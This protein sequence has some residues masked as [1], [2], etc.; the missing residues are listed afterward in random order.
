VTARVQ[1]VPYDD[2][3]P[4]LFEAEAE[5]IRAALGGELRVIEHVGSTS[6]PGLA[7]KPVIDIAIS[8]ESLDDLDIAAV[9]ELGYRYVPKFEEDLPNRKYFTRGDYH[10]HAYE[11]EHEDFMDYVRFRDYLRTHPE[12]ARAYGDLKLTL[13]AEFLDDRA[14][15]Q[16]AKA[17]YVARLV[18][19]LRRG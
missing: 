17:P 4:A 5:Q 8:V 6:V 18:A 11:Q 16:A 12:D 7:A 13:A 10:L 9:E 1:V 14:G 3:W 2:A 15:Y 19:A